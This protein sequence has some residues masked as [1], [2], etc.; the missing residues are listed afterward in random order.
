MTREEINQIFSGADEPKV[1]VKHIKTKEIA[2]HNHR[3]VN[4]LLPLWFEKF[5]NSHQGFLFP[6]YFW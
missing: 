4:Q 3:V 2:P 5:T 6:H 1:T